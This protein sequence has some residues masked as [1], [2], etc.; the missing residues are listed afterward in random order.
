MKQLLQMLRKRLMTA[1]LWQV[2]FVCAVIAIPIT[3]H[4]TQSIA[5]QRMRIAV[6]D[7]RGGFLYLDNVG[8]FQTAQSVH[9]EISKMAA[10]TIFNRSPDGFDNPE[11][12]TRL[13]DDKIA[14][15]LNKKAGEDSENFRI[16][17]VHQKIET[18][19]IKELSVDSNTALVSVEGQVLRQGMF[20]SKAFNDTKNLLVFFKLK[21]NQDMASNGRYPMIVENYE[22]RYK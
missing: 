8:S 3:N 21:V 12:I 13:F 1:V 4:V 22:V 10:E 16:G 20:N 5:M 6:P 17:Q 18:G 9:A 7:S 15:Y 19:D 14:E 2:L 11:R